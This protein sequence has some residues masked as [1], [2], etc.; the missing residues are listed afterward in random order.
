MG[1][2]S[3]YAHQVVNARSTWHEGTLVFKQETLSPIPDG[4]Q[5]CEPKIVPTD[6]LKP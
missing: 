1:R 3:Q 4:R 6:V 2:A 5:L